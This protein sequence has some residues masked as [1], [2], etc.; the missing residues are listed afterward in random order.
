[1]I[2]VVGVVRV[3]GLALIVFFFTFEGK[4]G[5]SFEILL[6]DLYRWVKKLKKN[7]YI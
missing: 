4:S 2:W 5:E 1:M 7:R 3:V 6:R